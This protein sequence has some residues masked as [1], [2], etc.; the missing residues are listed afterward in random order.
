MKFEEIFREMVALQRR[1]IETILNNFK[2]LEKGFKTGEL[3]GEWRI[4]PIEKP[5]IRGFIARGFFRTTEPLERP[6]DI[7][8]PLGPLIKEP[9]EPLYDI[10]EGEDAVQLYVELPGVEE[11]E[12]EINVDPKNLEVRARSFQTNVDLSKWFLNTKKI[13]T[14]YRNGV[15]KVTIPKMK[16]D[17]HRI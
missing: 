8:Q 14:E 6:Q 9:R 12:I 15:L 2:D 10:N 17:M 5:G 11:G 4:D 13:A 7:L 1:M 16:L 3:Q